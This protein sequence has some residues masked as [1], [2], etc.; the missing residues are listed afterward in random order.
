MTSL[1]D[2]KREAKV[3][4]KDTKAAKRVASFS[5]KVSKNVSESSIGSASRKV[6]EIRSR[7][8]MNLGKDESVV[9][10]AAVKLGAGIMKSVAAAPRNLLIGHMEDTI[11]ATKADYRTEKY[12][13][14]SENGGAIDE[15]IGLKMDVMEELQN[16]MRTIMNLDISKGAPGERVALDNVEKNL[17]IVSEDP[18]LTPQDRKVA[19]DTLKEFKAKRT[20]R[21]TLKSNIK[22]LKDIKKMTP[23]Q[24]ISLRADKKL[25]RNAKIG[26]SMWMYGFVACT[27]AGPLAAPLAAAGGALFLLSKTVKICVAVAAGINNNSIR[28]EAHGKIDDILKDIEGGKN[29]SEQMKTSLS[30]AGGEITPEIRDSAKALLEDIEGCELKVDEILDLLI[31]EDCASEMLVD[32][33]KSGITDTINVVNW[34]LTIYGAGGMGGAMFEGGSMS[35]SGQV[36]TDQFSNAGSNLGSQIDVNT[37]GQNAISGISDGSV[38]QLDSSMALLGDQVTEFLLFQFEGDAL[39]SS[40]DTMRNGIKAALGMSIPLVGT[41]PGEDIQVLGTGA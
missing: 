24:K 35:D 23:G 8:L 15:K 19:S 40:S 39:G 13:K 22:E 2:V 25:D 3:Y 16:D 21:N 31:K 18:T 29:I 6:T 7:D 14:L 30:K 41:G 11:D 33:I 17:K 10:T 4:L 26:N 27:V 1:S 34:G 37:I 38:F 20:K 28:K 36:F 32:N 12:C 5:N 9:L